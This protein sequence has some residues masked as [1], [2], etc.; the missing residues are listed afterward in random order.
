MVQDDSIFIY[1]DYNK[2]MI[3]WLIFYINFHL[4]LLVLHT[5][6]QLLPSP[7]SIP[8]LYFWPNSYACRRLPSEENA[9]SNHHTEQFYRNG[10]ASGPTKLCHFYFYWGVVPV[11]FFIFLQAAFLGFEG[12]QWGKSGK[13]LINRY[14]KI[15]R[16]EGEKD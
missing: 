8:R 4:L 5:H 12:P 11:V 6:I 1:A 14:K 16:R 2:R 7:H 10:S 9:N 3:C 13:D 15:R